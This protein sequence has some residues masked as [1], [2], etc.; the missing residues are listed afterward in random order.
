MLAEDP[1]H[2]VA[3][4]TGRHPSDPAMTAAPTPPIG[5]YRRAPV[6]VHQADPHA[7]EV[8]RRLIELI[9]TRWPGTPAEHVGSSAV[10]ELPG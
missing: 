9:A 4:L 3:D 1:M 5:P 2:S 10:P 7:P 6:E 8:A